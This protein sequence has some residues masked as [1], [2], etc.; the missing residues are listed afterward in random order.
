M[1]YTILARYQVDCARLSLVQI[2]GMFHFILQTFPETSCASKLI[3]RIW[4]LYGA[5]VSLCGY[6]LKNFGGLCNFAFATGGEVSVGALRPGLEVG[7]GSRI[8]TWPR[9][10]VTSVM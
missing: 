3:L 4:M 2:K 7:L 6:P 9:L 10:V 5:G 8:A 1:E